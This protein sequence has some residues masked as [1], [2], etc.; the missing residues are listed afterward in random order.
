MKEMRAKYNVRF[1]KV[2]CKVNAGYIGRHFDC[3]CDSHSEVWSR[4][5]HPGHWVHRDIDQLGTAAVTVEFGKG[6]VTL[7]K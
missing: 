7:T 2:Y 3:A 1:Q 6:V 5:G 4:R